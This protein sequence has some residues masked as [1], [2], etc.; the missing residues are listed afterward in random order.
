MRLAA[1]LA[2]AL[3][4]TPLASAPSLA[5]GPAK[6]RLTCKPGQALKPV[7]AAITATPEIQDAEPEKRALCLYVGAAQTGPFRRFAIVQMEYF[8]LW[9]GTAGCQVLVFVEDQ[10]GQ[11]RSAIDPRMSNNGLAK[12]EGARLDFSQAVQGLPAITV[13]QRPDM[14]IVPIVW[15]FDAE[16]GVY[17][18]P[19]EALD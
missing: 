18:R 15:T 5:A 8:P 16:A 6:I 11:W 17:R 1:V 12:E 4:V 7:V 13:P 9:C 10:N 2:L 14:E 3:I 19:E